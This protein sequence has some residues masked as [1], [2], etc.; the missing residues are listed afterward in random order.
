[1]HG[2]VFFVFLSRC[3]GVRRCFFVGFVTA[4]C[5]LGT[6]VFGLG[7][8]CRVGVAGVHATWRGKARPGSERPQP[9]A[10]RPPAAAGGSTPRR[11]RRRS[12]RKYC[13]AGASRSTRAAAATAGASRAPPPA[14]G[15]CRACHARRLVLWPCLM[16]SA[17]EGMPPHLPLRCAHFTHVVPQPWM[18]TPAPHTPRLPACSKEQEQ[19]MRRYVTKLRIYHKGSEAMQATLEEAR[20]LVSS[21]AGRQPAPAQPPSRPP[22]G[23]AAA[24]AT[25]AAG[26][27]H[28]KNNTP[29]AQDGAAEEA[30]VAQP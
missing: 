16:P 11:A 7:H 20:R 19:E 4:T 1:M 12:W 14:A 9:E 18:L 10:P 28:G 30:C 17:L 23:A 6:K 24:A 5:E 8:G 26:G 27:A 29:A 2:A 22:P 21:R 15:N 25:P 13:S 3:S